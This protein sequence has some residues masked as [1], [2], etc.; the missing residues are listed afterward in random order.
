MLVLIVHVLIPSLT[1][2]HIIR[3]TRRIVLGWVLAPNRECLMAKKQE[4]QI[5]DF[6][7]IYFKPDARWGVK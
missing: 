3:P 4:L 5:F 2:E 6:P 7:K 1:Q